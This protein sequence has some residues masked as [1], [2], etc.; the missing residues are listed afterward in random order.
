[1]I[2]ATLDP[3]TW[4]NSQKS[5]NVARKLKNFDIFHK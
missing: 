3:G 2:K 5:G 4:L 1:M